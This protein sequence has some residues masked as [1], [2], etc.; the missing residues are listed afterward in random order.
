MS[1]IKYEKSLDHYT[2]NNFIEE[3]RKLVGQPVHGVFETPAFESARRGY[4]TGYAYAIG[5][6]NPLY[7]D[8]TYAVDTRYAT[9][10]APPTFLVAFKYP[11]SQGVLFDGP[12]PLVGM[13]AAFDWE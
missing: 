7:T 3:C 5:D 2:V 9:Q 12:Y 8:I 13:E 11:V 1:D 4:L 10:I 6:L